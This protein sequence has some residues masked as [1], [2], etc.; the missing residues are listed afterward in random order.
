MSSRPAFLSLLILLGLVGVF[1]NMMLVISPVMR[2]YAYW[3]PGYL[4]LATAASAF[5]LGGLWFLKRWALWGY[6]VLFLLNQVVFLG[7][8]QWNAKAII[9][10][11]PIV[12]TAWLYRKIFK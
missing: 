6:S 3:F 10:P 11:L 5:F 9:L 7:L 2:S 8:N 4:S 1:L 12:L